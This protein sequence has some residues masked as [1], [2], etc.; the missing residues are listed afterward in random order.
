MAADEAYS[1]PASPKAAVTATSDA[2]SQ[3][4]C[5]ASFRVQ[6][7]GSKGPGTGPLTCL[8]SVANSP[9]WTI[10][11]RWH[12]GPAPKVSAPGPCSYEVEAANA[13]AGTT[14]TGPISF[15]KALRPADDFSGASPG[16]VYDTR[17]VQVPYVRGGVVGTAGS[18]PVEQV[19][20][21]TTPGPGQYSL[22]S[23]LSKKGVA[24]MGDPPKRRRRPS[25]AP[26]GGGRRDRPTSAKSAKETTEET[27]DEAKETQRMHAPGFSFGT[28]LRPPLSSGS[29]SAGRAGF[30]YMPP[31]TLGGPAA[32][33]RN[34]AAHPGL[35]A[36]EIRP[37]PCTY[38]VKEKRP[39][40]AYCFARAGRPLGPSAKVDHIG[41]GSYSTPELPVGRGSASMPRS[42]RERP[43]AQ[44]EEEAAPGPGAYD[45]SIRAGGG[46]IGSLACTFAKAT[47]PA[48]SDD[49]EASVSSTQRRRAEIMRAAFAGSCDTSGFSG[50]APPTFGS[51]RAPRFP[52]Q[53]RPP[54]GAR[55]RRGGAARSKA[56]LPGPGPGAFDPALPRGAKRCC[57]MGSSSRWA[58]ALK[59]EGNPGPGA[60]G[61]PAE[62]PLNR[63]SSNGVKLRPRSAGACVNRQVD[64]GP[65]PGDYKVYSEFV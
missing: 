24:A 46:G 51:C 39:S 53:R 42:L 5:S 28:G 4:N 40:H 20:G 52:S 58:P 1:P 38:E 18:K 21:S 43:R 44:D 63:G 55:S 41:P 23:T 56:P 6:R 8:A 31:S 48:A 22:T 26:A 11:G 25:S 17:R 16:P 32:S 33:C 54:G 59:N 19:M 34:G 64:P 9:K 60:Y 10:L 27:K 57:V 65:S 14:R 37:D 50:G 47:R 45:P 2:G 15:P 12:E 7:Q 62:N 36:Y 49:N 13:A 29:G 35:N 3:N 61:N 30:G